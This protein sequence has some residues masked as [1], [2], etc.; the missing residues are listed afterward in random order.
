MGRHPAALSGFGSGSALGL[1]PRVALSSAQVQSVYLTALGLVQ[2][3]LLGLGSPP[4]G[5]RQ[6]LSPCRSYRLSA[7]SELVRR[8]NVGD[9]TVQ[10]HWPAPKKLSSS[11]NGSSPPG[12]VSPG[13]THEKAKERRRGRAI[14]TR[15]RP[16]SDQ[17]THDINVLLQTRHRRDDLLSVATA[18]CS[19]PG[20]YQVAD[21]ASW[22][23]R[24]ITSRTSRRAAP[25]QNDAS[26]HR[27]KKW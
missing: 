16:R 14:T 10:T 17:R 23:S 11:R 8:S 22:S 6:F 15:S 18:T 1:R 5:G 26:G 3:R 21:T 9:G 27:K 12:R 4:G 20:R 24:S 19:R 25:G 7:T 2:F 13:G